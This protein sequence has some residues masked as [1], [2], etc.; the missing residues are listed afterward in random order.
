M[1]SKSPS[2]VNVVQSSETLLHSGSNS[3]ATDLFRA[4]TYTAD[5]RSSLAAYLVIVMVHLHPSYVIVYHCH[6]NLYLRAERYCFC[7]HST[8]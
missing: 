6:F 3:P 7:V 1:A 8:I 4:I 5:F 2:Q